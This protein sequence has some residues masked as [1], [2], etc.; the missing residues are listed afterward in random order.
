MPLVPVWRW[1]GI[2]CDSAIAIAIAAAAC[3]YAQPL[4]SLQPVPVP[5]TPGRDTYGRDKDALAALGKAFFGD[6]AAA[7]AAPD[8]RRATSTTAPTTAGKIKSSFYVLGT[9]SLIVRW[10]RTRE[11]MGQAR[12]SEH[13]G[14]L[15]VSAE[16]RP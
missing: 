5:E 16:A 8:A 14:Q 6:K 10:A 12:C 1:E 3:I 2:R 7:T 4:R 15:T 13:H 11:K 9:G